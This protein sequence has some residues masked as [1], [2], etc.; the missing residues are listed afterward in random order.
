MAVVMPR[1]RGRPT[2]QEM[3]AREA[4][5]KLGEAR[6]KLPDNQV[7]DDLKLRFQILEEL[8]EGA[9]KGGG[10]AVRAVTVVGGP[11][12]GKTYTI[13]HVLE[14]TKA[15]HDTISG[16]ISAIQLY[17]AGW[18]FRHPGN[19]L[20]LDDL[21]CIY[22]D[23]DT[24]NILKAMCDS[25]LE[26][27]VSYRKEAN[28]LKEEDI[29]QTYEYHGSII[30]VSNLDFQKIID[31]GRS[32]FV[33]HFEALMSRSLYLDLRIHERREIGMWIEHIAKEGAI[34][35][36]EGIT[37]KD[38]DIILKWLRSNRENLRQLSLRSLTN[39]CALFKQYGVKSWEP[40]ANVLLCK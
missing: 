27:V 32:K 24:M 8:T 1:K 37:S 31:E 33:P 21:D 13:H 26:R 39:A 7:L 10:D 25:S 40:R 2:K 16:T 3:A 30:F 6:K 28:S 22:A 23:E 35:T 19:V 29:P 12:V 14:R 34:F 17:K 4:M 15:P 38:G 11:G 5:K 36:R 20:V 18:Y 9:T